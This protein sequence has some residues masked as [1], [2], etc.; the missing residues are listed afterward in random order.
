MEWREVNKNRNPLIPKYAG[1][2][3]ILLE[4]ERTAVQMKYVDGFVILLANKNLPAY[5]RMAQ[6]AGKIWR[7]YRA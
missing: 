6:K 7:E 4:K 1:S 3:K 2:A 5:R